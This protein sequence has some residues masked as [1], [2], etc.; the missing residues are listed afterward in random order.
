MYLSSQYEDYISFL[1]N[2]E[3]GHIE[4]LFPGR[5]ARDQHLYELSQP[6]IDSIFDR[7][8]YSDVIKSKAFQR[9]K[10]I[11]FLGS[12]DYVIN[13][14]GAKPNKRHTRYQHSIGVARLALLYAKLKKLEEKEEVLCVVAALLH[15]I[16]HAPLSH[17]LESVF[18]KEYGIE[19]HVA[20]ERII[21]GDVDLGRDLYKVLLRWKLNPIELLEI[22]NG[23]GPKPYKDIFGYYINIDTIEAILRS[24]TYVY[25][26]PLFWPPS[27]VLK[28]LVEL[29]SESVQI[30]DKFWKLKDEVYKNII[31]Y[32]LG[33]LADY[34][35]QK[36]MS[37]NINSFEEN[38]Y[39]ATD[40]NL[41]NK[42]PRLFR[43]LKSLSTN[44][45]KEILPDIDCINYIDRRFFVDE[46]V[47][48]NCIRDI[49]KRYYQIKEQKT[50][51][52]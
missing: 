50:F 39:Y 28:A 18:Q 2:E 1:N 24:V 34:I 7:E 51:V 30:L 5:V 12:I 44:N 48:L 40:Q 14:E 41:K 43:F 38:Y 16:G 35:C 22:I 23:T 15:D 10:K 11:H 19:H 17:S 3:K 21:R 45:I 31:N 25:N 32:N 6:E 36:Y 47:E 4:S 8:V 33:M 37:A 26:T 9:L 46:K 27:D 29:N 20:G 49:N 42:H 52:L 13:P